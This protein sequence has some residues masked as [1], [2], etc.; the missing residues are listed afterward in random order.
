MRRIV[1][2]GNCVLDQVFE[3]EAFPSAGVKMTA[4]RFRE[5][6]GGPAATAA[7]AIARLGGR[8]SWWGRLGDDSAGRF[9]L[10]TLD[11]GGV[12]VGGVSIVPGARTGRAVVIVD[13]AGERSILVNRH[14]LPSDVVHL[15]EGDL[16]DRPVMLAD[17]RWPQ[18]SEVALARAKALGLPRVLDADGGQIDALERLAGLADHIVFSREGLRDLTGED[19]PEKQLRCAAERYESVLA[20]TCGAAGSLWWIDGAIAS[21][22]AFDVPVRDTT[23]CGDVFHGAYALGLAEGMAPLGAARFAAAVAA[24]KAEN[25]NG[26]GGMPDRA[27]VERLLGN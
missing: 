8:A 9:L 27:S 23:G 14:G 12:D 18:A 6:G 17:S 11:T 24:L 13:A 2:V 10:Q 20:V 16:S 19:E 4:R 22:P 7:L 25:G 21:V 26:W 1:C 3:V 5:G 15:V